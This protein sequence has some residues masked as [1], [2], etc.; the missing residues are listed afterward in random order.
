MNLFFQ[1]AVRCLPGTAFLPVHEIPEALQ[2]ISDDLMR[3]QPGS[4][5]L[6]AWFRKYYVRNGDRE[7]LFPPRLWVFQDPNQDR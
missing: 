2:F 3:I 7:A 1:V 6:V 4:E 5:E